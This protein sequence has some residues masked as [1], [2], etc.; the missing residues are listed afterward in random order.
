TPRPGSGPNLLISP[1][2]IAVTADGE[3][4]VVDA[5]RV[6]SIDGATGQQ[7]VVQDGVDPI[8]LG[9]SPRGVAAN[10]RDPQIGFFREIYVGGLG[11]L[12]RVDRSG[13]GA[14]VAQLAPYPQGWEHYEGERVVPHDPGAGGV[15]VWIENFR[16]MLFYD[17]D[18]QAVTPVYTAV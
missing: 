10:P 17:G 11:E 13:F 2:S 5:G 8:D 15:D 16:G 7:F 14:S 12:L 3:I 6:L 9:A 4:L 1:R 18:Q